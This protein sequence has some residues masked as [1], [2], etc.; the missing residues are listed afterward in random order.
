[1]CIPITMCENLI[2]HNRPEGRGVRKEYRQRC[3]DSFPF[4]LNKEKMLFLRGCF[5]D[6]CRYTKL[7]FF[8]E[9][10]G[11]WYVYRP[12]RRI[13]DRI[14]VISYVKLCPTYHNTNYLFVY[15]FAVTQY[16]AVIQI[17]FLHFYNQ[18]YSIVVCMAGC[19]QMGN[20]HTLKEKH[21]FELKSTN[22]VVGCNMEL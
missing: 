10:Y 1:M 14:K 7:S 5:F 20:H 11:F 18:L 12:S 3:A 15:I 21:S 9:E 4:C 22:F 8:T 17:F 19:N 6:I 16:L 13:V 2:L